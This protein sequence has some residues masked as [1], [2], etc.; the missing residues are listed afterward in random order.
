MYSRQMSQISIRVAPAELEKAARL[1]PVAAKLKRFDLITRSDVLREAIKQ[2]LLKLAIDLK[3][4][5]PRRR[6]K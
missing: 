5:K 1:V 3:P 2:G 4:P 6:R